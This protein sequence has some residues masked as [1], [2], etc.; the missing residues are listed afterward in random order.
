MFQIQPKKEK[1]DE[2][3]MDHAIVHYRRNNL[4]SG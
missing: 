3:T 2:E 1:K 4:R